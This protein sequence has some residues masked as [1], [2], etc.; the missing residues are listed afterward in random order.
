MG[1]I[2]QAK[3]RCGA[4]RVDALRAVMQTKMPMSKFRDVAIVFGLSMEETQTP[5]MLFLRDSGDPK[6]SLSV[7]AAFLRMTVETNLGLS[8]A[9][10]FQHIFGGPLL[11]WLDIG[12]SLIIRNGRQSSTLHSSPHDPE[13]CHGWFCGR[14]TSYL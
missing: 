8:R 6:Y 11:R 14:T 5:T 9:S 7:S 12:R 10:S 2:Y 4:C 3:V 13:I 1:T